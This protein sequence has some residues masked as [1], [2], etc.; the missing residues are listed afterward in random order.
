MREHYSFN[1]MELS[2]SLGDLG[3]ILPLAIAMV[4]M[5]GVSASGVFL[6]FGLYYIFSGIYFQVTS[7]V[8]PMKI[9]AAY[10]IASGITASQIQ[11][12]SLLIAILLLFLGGT[13]LITKIAR[14]IPLTVIRGVQLSTGI[15]L[16]IKGV[17]L[18]AGTSPF[19]QLHGKYP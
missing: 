14:W 16:I 3:T 13:G 9:I 1:R 17:Q 15:L 5:N 12:S 2:G 19:Q 7:P 11:S 4:I 10:A 18:L 6:C 8:E